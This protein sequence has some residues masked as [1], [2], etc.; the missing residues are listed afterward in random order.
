[1]DLAT[2]ENL[3]REAHAKLDAAEKRYADFDAKLDRIES[4]KVASKLTPVYSFGLLAL[5][6]WIG[7]WF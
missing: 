4:A 5:A 7:T 2:L 3:V 1:M 6:F